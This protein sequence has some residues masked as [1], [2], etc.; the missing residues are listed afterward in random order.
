LRDK[1]NLQ[2]QEII[3]VAMFWGDKSIKL[4]EIIAAALF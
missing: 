2:L 4:R 3:A 1:S